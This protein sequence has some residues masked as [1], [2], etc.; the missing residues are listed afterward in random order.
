MNIK[1]ELPIEKM[2]E[3]EFQKFKERYLNVKDPDERLSGEAMSSIRK[4]FALQDYNS[5]HIMCQEDHAHSINCVSYDFRIACVVDRLV[6]EI[7]N[8]RIYL[9]RISSDISRRT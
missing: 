3:N 8:Y 5:M 4:A 7:R 2:S 6:E 1:H 9:G